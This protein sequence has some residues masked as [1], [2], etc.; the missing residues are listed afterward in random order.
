MG[1][2]EVF[3]IPAAMSPVGSLL[4]PVFSELLVVEEAWRG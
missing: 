3:A 1:A 2:A 4:D